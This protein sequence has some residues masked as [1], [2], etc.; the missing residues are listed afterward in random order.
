MVPPVLLTSGSNFAL[1][2][3]HESTRAG[4][5][6][7]GWQ[8]VF[9]GSIRVRSRPKLFHSRKISRWLIRVELMTQVSVSTVWPLA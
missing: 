8:Q 9:D 6:A 3:N 7:L 2:R 1:D 5:D 4:S